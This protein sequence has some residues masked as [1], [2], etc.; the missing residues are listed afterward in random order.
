MF[1]CQAWD[2]FEVRALRIA[3]EKVGSLPVGEIQQSEDAGGRRFVIRPNSS[4]TWRNAKRYLALQ[5]AVVGLAALPM[6]WMGGWLVLPFAGVELLGLTVAFYLVVL[7]THRI[8]VV[9]VGEERVAVERGLHRPE[10]RGDLPRAWTRVVLDRPEGVLG[11]CR[12]FLRAHGQQLEVGA[13]L[14]APEK[15]HLARALAAALASDRPVD[16]RA[17]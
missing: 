14:T 6:V 17:I 5:G 3:L 1:F 11:V 2:R 9:T 4:L 10:E 15:E 7:R 8:E 13:S 12:L 16:R